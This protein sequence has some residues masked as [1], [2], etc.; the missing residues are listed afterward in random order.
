MI[1]FK[2]YTMSGNEIILCDGAVHVV[3]GDYIISENGGFHV[4]EEN[5]S[6]KF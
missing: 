4:Y 1:M 5:G 3:P 2:Y 6:L